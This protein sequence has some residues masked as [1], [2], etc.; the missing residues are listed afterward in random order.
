MSLADHLSRFP[1]AGAPS[2]VAHPGLARRLVARCVLL[3][4]ALAVTALALPQLAGAQA[5]PANLF[6]RLPAAVKS[7]K[8][9]KLTGDSFAPYRIVGDDGKTVSGIDIDL[10][11]AL[12]P[13]LGVKIEFTLVSNLPAM[14]AGIDTGRYDFSMGPLLS[15]KAREERY[16]I[17][18]WILSK[19]AFIIP[20]ASGKKAAK[21]EDM[22]GWRISF[23]AGSAQEEVIKQLTARCVAA[24]LP[25]MVPVGLTDQNATVLAAQSGRADVAG[26]Q[27]AGAL[28]LQSQNSG[29]FAVLTDA[30]DQLGI[31][32]QGFIIKKGTE[33]A[34]VLRDAMRQLFASGEYGR[35]MDKWNLG[36]AK[37]SEPRLNPSTAAAK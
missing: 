35:I 20:T 34:P 27:L 29:R 33:L 1:A 26:M 36:P 22:C 6:E 37:A 13:I 10:A 32:H 21:V 8:V 23:P 15:T 2:R 25:A 18:T 11:R 31:L 9:L 19:P 5:R 3:G 24:K 17:L 12:E 16:D 30:T 28:Y 7:A 4:A 14:L